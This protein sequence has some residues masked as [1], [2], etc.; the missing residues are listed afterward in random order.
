M[1]AIAPGASTPACGSTTAI[2]SNRPM[3]DFDYIVAP[4]PVGSFN[5][6][7]RRSAS[8]RCYLAF[9]SP[10]ERTAILA[11]LRKSGRPGDV[12]AHNTAKLETGSSL[13]SVRADAA[14]AIGI[15]AVTKTCREAR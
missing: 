5:V 11:R 10:E 4:N 14:R 9:C 8:G 3:S 1:M 7:M 12:L 2:E 13:M 15:L 6:N